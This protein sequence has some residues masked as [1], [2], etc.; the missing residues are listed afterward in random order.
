MCNEYMNVE[1]R[2]LNINKNKIKVRV[3]VEYCTRINHQHHLGTFER[4]DVMC[5]PIISLN[6]K[7]Y[8]NTKKFNDDPHT[9][10][11]SEI[12][13]ITTTIQEEKYS[14]S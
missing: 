1:Y 6:L 2:F 3:V 8:T 14:T 12:L 5:L 9:S 13:I 10:I 4:F 11:T 7:T